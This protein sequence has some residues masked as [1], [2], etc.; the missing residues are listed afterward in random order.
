MSMMEWM[1]GKMMNRMSKEEKEAMMDGAMAKMMD[2]MST[3]EKQQMMATMMPKMMEGVRM[4]EMMPKMMLTMMP[5]MFDEVKGIMAEQGKEFDLMEV[6]PRVMGPFMSG[7][8]EVVPAEAMVKKKEH[9]FE[10]V[11]EQRSE[12]RKKIPARQMHMMPGCMRRL[13]E[14]ISYEEK[15]QYAQHILGILVEKG[16]ENLSDTERADYLASLRAIIPVEN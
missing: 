15:V 6:M 4:V 14:N 9:M 2:G 12:L 5:M 13:M 7:M 3:E 1:M 11:F 8:L 16:A 10:Q